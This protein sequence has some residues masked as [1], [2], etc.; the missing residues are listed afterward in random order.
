MAQCE[1]VS[2]LKQKSCWRS[3][4]GAGRESGSIKLFEVVKEGSLWEPVKERESQPPPNTS[5]W[6]PRAGAR[7]QRGVA[8]WPSAWADRQSPHWAMVQLASPGPFPLKPT[9][10]VPS[11][12]ES[13]SWPPANTQKHRLISSVGFEQRQHPPGGRSP[14]GIGGVGAST[15]LRPL[16]DGPKWSATDDNP[17]LAIRPFCLQ[18]LCRSTHPHGNSGKAVH[19]MWVG[20]EPSA[21]KLGWGREILREFSVQNLFT[22]LLSLGNLVFGSSDLI[23]QTLSGFSLNS[24]QWRPM[25]CSP[26]LL[27]VF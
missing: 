8:V 27:H 1:V 18:G 2:Q 25:R 16:D 21:A 19:T 3:I 7:A 13:E 10:S 12:W 24:S 26:T 6:N 15:A 4:W 14:A 11:L 9:P 20:T 5:L 17:H 23:S 22:F